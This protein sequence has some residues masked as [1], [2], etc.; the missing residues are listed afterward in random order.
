LSEQYHPRVEI[1]FGGQHRKRNPEVIEL[2]D[3]IAVKGWKA[4]GNRLTAYEVKEIVELEPLRFDPRLQ[5]PFRSR[6][7]K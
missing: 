2:S 1:R 3:F 5:N 7:K 4:K 6:R